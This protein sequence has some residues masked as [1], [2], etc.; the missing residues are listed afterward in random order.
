MRYSDPQNEIRKYSLLSPILS[1]VRKSQSCAPNLAGKSLPH[2]AIKKEAHVNR[3]VDLPAL[4]KM[5]PRTLCPIHN[6]QN[7]SR[8]VLNA[9]LL[10]I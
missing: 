5:E 8:F 4:P 7:G 3:V 1:A 10:E 9:R 2:V 6:N